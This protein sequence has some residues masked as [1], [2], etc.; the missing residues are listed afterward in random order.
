MQSQTPIY[1]IRAVSTL[2]FL[3][4]YL[5]NQHFWKYKFLRLLKRLAHEVGEKQISPKSGGSG[6]V[7]NFTLG[8][9]TMV[10]DIGLLG[11]KQIKVS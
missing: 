11:P 2:L 8:M 4:G 1:T 9:V 10:K 7:I 3:I 6:S 5:T